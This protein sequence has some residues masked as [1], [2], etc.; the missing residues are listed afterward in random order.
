MA[1]QRLVRL[2]L[3]TRLTSAA[4]WWDL[5]RGL[6]GR[7]ASG[8]PSPVQVSA[9]RFALRRTF[10]FKRRARCRGSRSGLRK[11]LAVLRTRPLDASLQPILNKAFNQ[12]LKSVVIVDR[13]IGTTECAVSDHSS[14]VDGK[15]LAGFLLILACA[16]IC[17]NA[18]HTRRIAGNVSI[19]CWSRSPF[20]SR[21]SQLFQPAN[22]RMRWSTG[23]AWVAAAAD[24]TW[25]EKS[26]FPGPVMC[27]SAG[28]RSIGAACG[29]HPRT[30]LRLA[31][32]GY[33]IVCPLGR[34]S[35]RIMKIRISLFA[36]SIGV[37]R[38]M[39]KSPLSLHTRSVRLAQ[40]GFR[41]GA[42]L[43]I[44]MQRGAPLALKP[45]PIPLMHEFR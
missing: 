39:R 32:S 23:I 9:T 17:W 34:A 10:G 42:L 8:L 3:R 13:M 41:S 31:G 27:K 19:P 40:S 16:E 22:C 21:P 18:V 20:S 44:M 35:R 38:G 11:C 36:T 1:G 33:R 45:V 37:C 2:R 14:G 30:I 26:R 12:I 7:V 4:A 15:R 29:R 25:I 24:K 28:W 6:S 5:V 43:Y